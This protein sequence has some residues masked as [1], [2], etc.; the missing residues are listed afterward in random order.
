[1]KKF[2]SENIMYRLSN[3]NIRKTWQFAEAAFSK[4]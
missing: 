2:D 3:S 1:M 4:S